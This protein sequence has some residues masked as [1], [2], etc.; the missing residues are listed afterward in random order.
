MRRGTVGLAVLVVLTASSFT[1]RARACDPWVPSQQIIDPAQVGVDQTPPQLAQPSVAEL[2]TTDT[3]G[4][5]CTP[6]CG[7]DHSARLANLATD[8]TTPVDKIG[9]RVALVAGA[10]AN[11]STGLRN[12]IAVLATPVGLTVFWDGDDDFDFT[13][14]VVAVDAA[15]NE[16]AP[17]TVTISSGGG[18][19]SVGHRRVG[20]GVALA[21]ITLALATARARRRRPRRAGTLTSRDPRCRWPRRATHPPRR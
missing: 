17:R 18:G 9:Y 10:A 1:G 13:I 4:T 21:V 15:G 2:H 12:D 6:K 5:G 19:C 8:D 7:S 11:L 3:G 16:S 14:Q 20:D